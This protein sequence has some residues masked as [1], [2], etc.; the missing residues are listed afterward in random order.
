LE[1]PSNS[2]AMNHMNTESFR[3][4]IRQLYSSLSEITENIRYISNEMP[5]LTIPQSE[6]SRIENVCANFESAIYDVRKE[7]R[8]LEDKLGMHP[9]EEPFES[10]LNPD[11]RVTMRFIQQWLRTEIEAMHEL[12]VHLENVSMDDHALGIPFLLVA[13]SAVN[14]LGAY[15][16][17]RL[18]LESIEASLER[19]GA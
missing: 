1:V 8:N 2:G 6:R 17:I 19:K 11:P 7:I 13:G 18:S 5:K 12:V 14:I 10:E 15:A 4:P 16:T 9:G 3:G